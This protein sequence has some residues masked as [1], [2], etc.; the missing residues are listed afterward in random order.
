MVKILS[1]LQETRVRF[2]GWKDPLEKGVATHSSVLAWRIPWQEEP[3]GLQS[4]GL[5][6][7]VSGVQH[8]DSVIHLHIF[9]VFQIILFY[10]KL[11]I[12]YQGIAD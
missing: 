3:G 12:L 9:I 10:F 2:L 8:S 1:V 6:D 7:L 4:M 5:S 11:F